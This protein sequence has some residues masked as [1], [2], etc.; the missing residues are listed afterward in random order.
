[1]GTAIAVTDLQ[2]LDMV[3]NG[4]RELVMI[5]SAKKKINQFSIV[6]NAPLLR[7]SLVANGSPTYPMLCDAL[8]EAFGYSLTTALSA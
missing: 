7:A 5:P 2:V 4:I 1:M 6:K 8:L 3:K